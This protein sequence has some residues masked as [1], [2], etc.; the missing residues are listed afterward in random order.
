MESAVLI[1]PTPQTIRIIDHRS[2]TLAQQPSWPPL[3]RPFLKWAGGKQ[4][5]VPMAR[6]LLPATFEGTY[7]EPFVGGGALFFALRPKRAILGDINMDLI[8]AYRTVRDDVESLIDILETY[9]HE[10]TFYNNLRQTKPR[11]D[12]ER[13]ARFIY[14]NKTAY[15]GLYRV[16]LRGE[17]NVPFGKF[18]NPSICQRDR[19]REAS[20][21]LK[22]RDLLCGDFSE[23]LYNATVGDFVFLDPP[24]ITGHTNNGFLKYNAPLFSWKDQERLSRAAKSLRERG[25]RVVISNAAHDEILRLY[26]GFFNYTVERSSR[27]GGPV[28]TRRT[29]RESLLSSH[30]LPGIPLENV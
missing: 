17:F 26:D 1:Q 6:H 12:I 14:F 10:R 19:L 28:E 13:S 7:Y 2:Q 18:I 23:A 15:N 27:I 29:I 5:L 21:S 22:D 25:V 4:W 8:T 24:Y 11:D 9:P 16:N 3:S 20:K 30:A